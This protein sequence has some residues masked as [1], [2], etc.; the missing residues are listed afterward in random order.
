[1]S[2]VRVEA[3]QVPDDRPDADVH[4]RLRNGVRVLSQAGAETAAEKDN[5]HS[6]SPW[7]ESP[8]AERGP[9][10]RGWPKGFY[11]MNG[12]M[13]ALRDMRSRKT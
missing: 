4:Q 10:E 7:D 11:P 8:A 5:F 6:F 2:E 9:L 1:V 12:A 3:H 13:G